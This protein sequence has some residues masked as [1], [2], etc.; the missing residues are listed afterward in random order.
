MTSAQ[1]KDAPQLQAGVA[2]ADL[3]PERDVCLSGEA[4]WYRPGRIVADPLYAKALVFEQS[5][6]KACIIYLDL[7]VV[8]EETTGRLRQTLTEELGIAPEAIM[9]HATQVHTAPALGEFMFSDKINQMIP[10]ELYWLKGA[11]PGYMAFAFDRIID[12]VR[13]ADA[14][15]QPV[16]IRVGSGIE[17]RVTFNRRAVTDDGS[18]R[19]PGPRWPAGLGPTYIRYLE[20]PIDPELGVVCIQNEG[21]QPLALLLHHTCHPVNVFPKQVISSDW[22]GTWAEEMRRR[23]GENCVALVLNG[24]CGNINPWDPFDPDFKADHRRMGRILAETTEKVLETLEV[25]EDDT[26]DYRVRHLKI[27]LRDVEPEL[28]RQAEADLA[29]HP[30]PYWNESKA[31]AAY[32][33]AQT[34]GTRTID[35]DWMTA[36]SIMSVQHQ[37]QQQTELDYEIQAFRV[38]RTAIVALPGEPFVEGQLRIKMASPAYKTYVAHCCNAYAGYLP[39]PEAFAG[40]GHEVET[41]N[42]SKLVP[43]A[44][45]SVVDSAIELLHEM[46]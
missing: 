23:S 15:L 3:T 38:G 40:G 11:D 10:D 12:A 32:E 4:G 18:V 17:A 19:M 36:A 9:V 8:T 33:G 45:D 46:F 2:Q 14:A 39:I 6:K 13:R 28:L 29:Q 31:H 41:R 21:P 20:G 5:G 34:G 26:L 24:C 27:P 35:S 25:E 30:E 42:W 44:L 43:E 16:R 1:K 22:P 37:R 7:T